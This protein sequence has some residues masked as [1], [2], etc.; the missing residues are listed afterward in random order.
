MGDAAGELADGLH[1]LR[2]AELLLAGAEG[3]LGCL[4]LGDLGGDAKQVAV[5]RVRQ[6][7]RNAPQ[8]ERARRAGPRVGN[9]LGR[10]VLRPAHAITW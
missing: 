1:L 6:P 9:H 7:Q 10:H 4:A 5:G 8:F 3:V 2:L